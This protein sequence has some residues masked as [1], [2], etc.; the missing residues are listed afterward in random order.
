MEIQLAFMISPFVIGLLGVATIS[1]HIACTRDFYIMI[2]A[3]QSS[4]W[5]EQ[6][7]RF[8]GSTSVK[9]RWMLVSAALN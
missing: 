3:T 5:L 8:W 9:S 7:K 4:P 6:Q 1:F 2:S